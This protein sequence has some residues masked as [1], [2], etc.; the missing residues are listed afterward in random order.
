MQIVFENLEDKPQ[1]T[2]SSKKSKVSKAKPKKDR[3]IN[4]TQEDLDKICEVYSSNSLICKALASYFFTNEPF[5]STSPLFS[6]LLIF[7]F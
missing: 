4:I 2:N 1:K 6:C 5:K 3:K 7:H